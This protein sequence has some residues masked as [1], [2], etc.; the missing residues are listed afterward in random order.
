MY[1]L[2]VVYTYTTSDFQGDNNRDNKDYFFTL[3][4]YDIDCTIDLVQS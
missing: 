4:E 1:Y 3:D 2:L